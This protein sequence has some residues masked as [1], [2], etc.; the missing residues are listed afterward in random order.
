MAQQK[1]LQPQIFSFLVRFLDSL[2]FIVAGN[3][4]SK[5]IEDLRIATPPA[6]RAGKVPDL[7]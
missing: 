3:P 4:G 2:G 5:Q 1:Y 6:L 7:L